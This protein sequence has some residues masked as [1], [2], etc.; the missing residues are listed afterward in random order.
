MP[1][2]TNLPVK[3]SDGAGSLEF[4]LSRNLDGGEC[5]ITLSIDGDRLGLTLDQAAKLAL[6]GRKIEAALAS[7]EPKAA[8]LFEHKI[9][10]PSGE[11]SSFSLAVE[12]DP[13]AVAV[14]WHGKRI[15]LTADRA[16]DLSGLSCGALGRPLATSG[17][18]LYHR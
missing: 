10:F 6:A 13:L 12:T 15:T 14:T 5:P 18:R 7:K 4:V 2:I 16:C 9:G 1:A 8:V 17:A 11:V 3:I